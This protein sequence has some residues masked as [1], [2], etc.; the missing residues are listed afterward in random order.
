MGIIH[1]LPRIYKSTL[2]KIRDEFEKD[3]LPEN[4][5]EI[6]QEHIIEIQKMIN[7]LNRLDIYLKNCIDIEMLQK[8]EEKE[9]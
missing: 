9:A 2:D 5:S 7:H 3:A 8:L 4:S 6:S 1:L